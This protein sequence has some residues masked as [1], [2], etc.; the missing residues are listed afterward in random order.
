M[1]SEVPRHHFRTKDSR[2]TS[3][4]R[5]RTSGPSA[6]RQTSGLVGSRLRR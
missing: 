5:R 4:W 2:S 3:K 1:S 6:E